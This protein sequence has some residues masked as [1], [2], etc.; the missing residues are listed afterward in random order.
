MMHALNDLTS[1]VTTGTMKTEEA[2]EYSLIYCATNLDVFIIFY[3]R[4]M[5][6]RAEIVTPPI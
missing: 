2:K 1:Q 5:V 6:I 3:A 4:D